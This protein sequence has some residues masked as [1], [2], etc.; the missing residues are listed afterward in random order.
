M[1]FWLIM[2]SY[3]LSLQS[4]EDVQL[5]LLISSIE[6]LR[7][8]DFASKRKTPLNYVGESPACIAA[9]EESV[10]D[11]KTIESITRRMVPEW[12][13]RFEERL[14]RLERSRNEHMQ[15][16]QA[17]IERVR[18]LIELRTEQQRK[19]QVK[20]DKQSKKLRDELRKLKN[21]CRHGLRLGFMRLFR[22]TSWRF[23]RSA[24]SSR[25]VRLSRSAQ[26]QIQ[27]KA[28]LPAVTNAVVDD[29]VKQTVDSVLM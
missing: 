15:A 16:Y 23:V 12:N 25:S 21:K 26:V 6:S 17:H 18:R 22:V 29:I 1:L 24:R 14:E 11:L 10:K 27:A 5:K 20:Q 28:R 7:Y 2:C 4:T 9:D 19:Q 3:D 13:R 8:I